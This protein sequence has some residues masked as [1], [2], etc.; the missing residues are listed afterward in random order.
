MTDEEQEKTMLDE[1]KE[2][3]RWQLE[4]EYHKINAISQ[5]QVI[6]LAGLETVTNIQEEVISQLYTELR[7]LSNK[8]GE[9]DN[10]K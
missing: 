7:K 9:T 5:G 8:K 6:L 10:E 1:I 3:P 4:I 2:M